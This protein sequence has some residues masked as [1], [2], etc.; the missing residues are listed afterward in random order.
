MSKRPQWIPRGPDL[1]GIA[2]ELTLGQM[3][4]ALDEPA[5]RAESRSIP[6]FQ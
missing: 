4:Q 6:A 1:S 5:S 3:E 2:R